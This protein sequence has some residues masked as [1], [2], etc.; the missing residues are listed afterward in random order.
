MNVFIG[1]AS[2]KTI[3]KEYL[4]LASDVANLLASKEVDLVFGGGDVSMMGECFKAFSE[5]KRNIEAYTVKFYEKDLEELKKINP[6]AN[7]HLVK[8]TLERFKIM[9]DLTDMFIIL[10]GGIGT[11]A[12]FTSALEEFRSN[13]EHKMIVIY[14]HNGYYNKIFEW[15]NQNINTGFLAQTLNNDYKVVDSLELLEFYVNDYM[16]NTK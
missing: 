16:E 4:E 12:E 14:N 3:D 5:H 15:M 11:L 7:C 13:L 9:Y 10:P 1:C 8:D 6:N 2:S